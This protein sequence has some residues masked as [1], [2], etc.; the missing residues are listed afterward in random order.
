MQPLTIHGMWRHLGDEEAHVLF[1]RSKQKEADPGSAAPD[2]G[3]TPGDKST[4]QKRRRNRASMV[5]IFI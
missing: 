4:D 2:V 1:G 5:E 3:G